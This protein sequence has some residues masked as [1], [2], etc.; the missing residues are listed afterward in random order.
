MTTPLQQAQQVF[1]AHRGTLRTVEA[2]RAGIHPRTLY[3]LR[4]QGKVEQVSRGLY[5]LATLPA[6]GEPDLLAV[7]KRVPRAVFCLL[8]ALAFHRLTTQVPHVVAI[9]LPRTA[10]TPRLDH[11]PLEVFR[12]SPASL[13]AGVEER[14]VDGV[15]MRIYSPEKTLA[16]VF[17][18]RHKLGSDVAIEALRT[19]RGQRR[20]DWQQVLTFARVCRVENVMRPYLEAVM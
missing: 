15:L 17:K 11:P 19:Y 6:P 8:T 14:T 10:R 3:A 18:Y 9:A 12:F 13:G 1:V 7:A 2:Q 16:D 5:R 4:D 20:Q